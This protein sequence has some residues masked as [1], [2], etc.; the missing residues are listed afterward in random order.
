MAMCLYMLRVVLTSKGLLYVT[1]DEI[2]NLFHVHFC[3]F[4]IYEGHTVPIWKLEAAKFIY[5][6]S[7]D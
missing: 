7:Q 2:L 1:L 6:A 4:M 3:C 5:F